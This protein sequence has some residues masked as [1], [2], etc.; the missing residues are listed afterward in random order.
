MGAVRIVKYIKENYSSSI[1][2][3]N[4]CQA[5]LDILNEN[6]MFKLVN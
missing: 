6:K 3:E 2:R 4:K 1:I 5:L